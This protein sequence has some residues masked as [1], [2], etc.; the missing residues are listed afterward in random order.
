MRSKI[1][2][3]IVLISLLLFP[4][5]LNFFSPYVSIDGAINGII[6]GS[7]IVFFIMFLTGLF[8]GRAWCAWVCPMACLSDICLSVNDKPVN[9]LNALRLFVTVSLHSMGGHIDC[10]VRFGRRDTWDRSVASYG[11]HHLRG[12]AAKICDL[13]WCA[14][15]LHDTDA[16][17]RKARRLPQYMLDVTRFWSQALHSEK[18]FVFRNCA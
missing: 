1:R 9:A 4:V 8:F 16:Y 15:D 7:L 2:R 12:Y 17:D 6:S 18:C 10:H 11:K 3:T 13:L 14:R 5:T